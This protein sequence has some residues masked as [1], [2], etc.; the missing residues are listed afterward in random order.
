MIHFLYLG[1]YSLNLYEFGNLS[2]NFICFFHFKN[3]WYGDSF[4][5]NFLYYLLGCDNL[6]YFWLYWYNFFYNSRDLFNNLLDIWNNPF[7]LFDFLIDN[8]L[9]YYF[10][11]L[12]DYSLFRSDM[13]YFLYYLR[14]LDNS[15]NTII[16]SY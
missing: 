10:L 8:H 16:Q 15:L 1:H 13:Y 4:L 6:L 3:F 7:D 2:D 11:N 14:N 12:M 5:Y 9:L